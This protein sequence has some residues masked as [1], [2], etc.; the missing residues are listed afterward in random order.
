[1]S[2]QQYKRKRNFTKTPE[3][4]GGREKNLRSK[5][6]L[7]FVV[8]KHDATRL[9]YDFRLE[10]D[11]VLKSWAVPKGPSLNPKE[12]RL[13]VEVE[14]HP[15]EYGEFEGVIPYGQY[16]GGTVMLWDRGTWT[17]LDADPR[18][19][20]RKGKLT[21]KL[22]GEKLRGEWTLVRMHGRES[23]GKPNWLLMK[24]D[25]RDAASGS[26]EVT[27]LAMLSV[28]SGRNLD[29]IAKAGGQ[30]RKRQSEGWAEDQ[31]ENVKVRGKSSLPRG[32]SA[33]LCTLA[34]SVPKGEE[35][36]HEIK[37]DGYRLL[38]ERSGTDVHLITRGKK[39]WTTKFSP[40]AEEI[41]ALPCSD[42]IMDGE[43]VILD[44]N[45]KTSFQGL[46]QAI[47]LRRFGSLVF[48]VFDLLYLDG[49]DL[50]RLGLLKRKEMLKKLLDR[51]NKLT[52]LR[53]S[54]HVRGDGTGV[55]R[56]ACRLGLEGVVSKLADAPYTPGRSKTWLKIKC[57]RRQEFVI[58]GFTEPGG[59]RKH[60][61]A[62]LLGARDAS[63]KLVYTGKVG[64]GFDEGTLRTIGT[65]LRA[66][67]VSKNML[68]RTPPREE[69]RGAHW[70]KP[71]MVAEISFT[72]WT[73]DGRLRHPSFEGL[74]DDKKAGEVKIEIAK[75]S[76]MFE[77]RRKNRAA[78][79]STA[80]QE[81]QTSESQSRGSLTRRSPS[82]RSRKVA[83]SGKPQVVSTSN[84]EIV[85]GVTITHPERVLFTESGVSKL[86]LAEYYAAVSKLI[87]PHL[88]DRPLS[89]L[90]CVKGLSDQC[91]FQKHLRETFGPPVRSIRVREKSGTGDYIAIDSTEGLVKLVQMGVIEIHPWGSTKEDLEHPDQITFDL[92]PGEGV[93][94]D[95]VKDG[96]RDVRALLEG[97]GLRSFVK[98]SGGKGL[99]VVVPLEPKAGWDDI[100]E[101]AGGIARRL[102]AEAP[103]KYVANMSKAKRQGKIF[104]DYLRNGRGA[105]SVAPFCVRARQAGA[106]AMPLEWD[107]LPELRSA[108]AFTVAK[109]ATEAIAH[110]NAWKDFRKAGRANTKELKI[111]KA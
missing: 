52:V 91:F 50:R 63:G 43:A 16:G 27:A 13:A 89:V 92:D 2:L 25:D 6:T 65:K 18:E 67:E 32:I 40:I 48:Y 3:P 98:T 26:G 14:D 104:V 54:D 74:R 7:S 96:A 46:Q 84:G 99:H 28:K 17:P 64:T 109:G 36:L 88:V 60:F 41:A 71:R 44:K 86:G 72:E 11:G 79:Q 100:K 68:E 110:A 101:Y 47:K 90:R 102:A 20:L 49:K 66:S 5:K 15:L 42:V 4:S 45:G 85:A 107:E 9:H 70:V 106:I 58:V 29:A 80:N 22:H 39:D 76:E 93:P 8:Q 103:A 87:L 33:Q 108:D 82:R 75:P 57:G 62:L 21:F 95:R 94:F 105:T 10:L 69:T 73:E 23:G 30:A 61:G 31:R 111:S 56:N 34:D 53:Y 12:K 55:E 37:F 51:G 83:P 97:E 78:A 81:T 35:W 38:G 24:Q 19:T 77:T 59:G 1:M